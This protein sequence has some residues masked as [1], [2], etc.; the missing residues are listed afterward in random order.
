MGHTAVAGDNLPT[1][2]LTPLTDLKPGP[3]LAGEP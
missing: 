3:S 2:L 1:L